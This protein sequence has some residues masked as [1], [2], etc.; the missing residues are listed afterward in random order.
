MPT[1]LDQAHKKQQ[2]IPWTTIV[3][4][5]SRNGYSACNGTAHFLLHALQKNS[6]FNIL[7]AY[8]LHNFYLDIPWFL[9]FVVPSS[10]TDSAIGDGVSTPLVILQA[11][12]FCW[13]EPFGLYTAAIALFSLLGAVAAYN[14]PGSY[15]FPLNTLLN[16]HV[17]NPYYGRAPDQPASLLEPIPIIPFYSAEPG[18]VYFPVES[19]Y[20][21]SR[22]SQAL[23]PSWVL[24]CACAA[25]F[26][27]A[28]LATELQ[29]IWGILQIEL[30]Q[31]W[32]CAY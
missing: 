9:I 2:Y 22:P 7:G 23:C 15:G 19:S 16:C 6:F 24:W 11:H 17:Q 8:S 29:D 20:V 14:D 21:E 10:A 30:D 32:A 3:L 12:E 13:I 1:L 31:L 25:G 5:Y 4:F 28:R 27:L 26:R 18:E